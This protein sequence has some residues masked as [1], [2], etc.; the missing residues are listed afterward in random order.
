MSTA[1]APVRVMLVEPHA[2]LRGTV[3]GVVRE[4]RDVEV[5]AVASVASARRTLRERPADV[6]VLSLDEETEAFSLLESLRAAEGTG[7]DVA[8]AVTAAACDAATAARL[9][10]L[11]VRRL[12]LKPF[13]VRTVAD[14]VTGLCAV[15]AR[16]REGGSVA[17]PA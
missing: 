7:A 11:G 6:L 17:Q 15:A 12:L 16:L 14:T 13:K 5:H 4:L 9:K 8:I 2:V 10:H 1:G 3:A